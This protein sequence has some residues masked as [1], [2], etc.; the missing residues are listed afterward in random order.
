MIL[1]LRIGLVQPSGEAD[2]AGDAIEFGD[3]EAVFGQEDIGA[4]DAG[5]VDFESAGALTGDEFRRLAEVEPA[6]DPIGLLAFGTA[7]IKQVDG[8][9]KLEEDPAE[10]FDFASHLFSERKGGGGDM[11]VHAGEQAVGWQGITNKPRGVGGGFG[12]WDG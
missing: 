12:C 2:A 8:A 3:A 10:R 4:D 1:E 9:I 6:G 5:H 7:A 11:P